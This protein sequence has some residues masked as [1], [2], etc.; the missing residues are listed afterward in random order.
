[1]NSERGRGEK[2]GANSAALA[3]GTTQTGVRLYNERLVLSLIRQH[4][5]L[6]KAEL[7]KLTG[8]SAQTVSVIVRQLETDNFLTKGKAQRGKVGQPLT[9]FSLNPDGAFSIGLK[10]GRRSGDLILVDLAG[11]VRSIVRQPY[12]FPTPAAFLKFAKQGIEKLSSELAP[13]LRNRIAGLGIAAPFELWNWE[14]E[15]GAPH[16]VLMAWRDFD[17][18]AEV[19]KLSELPVHPCNDATAACAAE[20][21]FGT[22]ARAQ[23][24]AYFYVGY[25]IGGGL[26]LNGSLFQGR[27]GNAGA[28]GS[29][30]IPRNGGG[31]EQLIRSASLYTLEQAIR[32]QGHDENIL[33]Q[34]PNDWQQF[35]TL[36]NDWV[37]RAARGIAHACASIASVT[38]C[39][40]I[41]I[42]GAIPET[43]RRDLI[44]ATNLA[45]HKVNLS[46]I[47]HFK[48]REG[49]I[50]RDARALGAA[51][52]PLF[53]NFIIDR[54]VLF[55]EAAHA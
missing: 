2:L 1:V 40:E 25:F 36:V 49:A 18:M 47:S 43:V 48:L 19:A 54:D 23:D 31:A 34:S 28:L 9:P 3:R 20:L 10:V 6:P 29:I 22:G 45:L 39:S 14:E 42:D 7:A 46:G 16:E 8:L 13:H 53:A 5:Q 55:K 24:F 17:L 30:L 11:N 50:G 35:S 37:L 41:V 27:S 21:F 15:A 26:V 12:H 33:W 51:S 32:E 52:L 38:E 44:N 4:G